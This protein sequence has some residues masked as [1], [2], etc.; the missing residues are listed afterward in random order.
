MFNVANRTNQDSTADTYKAIQIQKKVDQYFSHRK[1]V[2]SLCFPLS[3]IYYSY[4]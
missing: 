1:F 3:R 4:L 2:Y